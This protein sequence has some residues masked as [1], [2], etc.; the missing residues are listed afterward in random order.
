MSTSDDEYLQDLILSG[1][2]EFAGIDPV[3]G[4]MLYS[5]TDK[6]RSQDPKMY[7]RFNDL[8]IS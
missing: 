2:V 8:F 7:D 1:A 4:E 3:T 5:I 6:L